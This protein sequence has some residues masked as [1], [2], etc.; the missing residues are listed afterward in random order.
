MLTKQISATRTNPGF[1]KLIWDLLVADSLWIRVDILGNCPYGGPSIQLQ[2]ENSD[3][4]G[5]E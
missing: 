1:V 4:K 5:V 3:G 2:F